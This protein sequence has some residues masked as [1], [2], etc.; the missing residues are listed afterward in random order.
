MTTKKAILKIMVILIGVLFSLV[1]II[2]LA[3]QPI[4]EHVY[5]QQFDKKPLVIAHAGSDLYPTD[6]MYAFE[7]YAAMGVDILEMDTNMTKDGK[8]VVIHDSKLDRTTDGTGDISELTLEESQ[9][10]DAAYW[11]TTDDGETYP[12][13]GEGIVIPSLRTV[14]ETFPEYPMIIEIKQ[15]SPSMAIPL[16]KLIR[17]YDMSERVLVP[18]FSDTAIN[19]FRAACPEVATAASPSEVKEFVI[20]NFLLL[21]GT[22]KPKYQE[23]QV[24]EARDGIPIVNRFFL[25]ST[26]RMNIDVHIWTIND[27]GE[28]QKFIDM[29][30]DGIMTDRTDLLIE[31]L[32]QSDED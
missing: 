6:T 27:S 11:W 23:L 17:E 7:H 10:Y 25:W 18:S 22:I 30:V 1:L 5:F 12:L 2:N 26:G 19:E 3:Q 14:F 28:M 15:E 31:I 4:P 29:N 8:I 21:S 16:C 9:Q 24:P 20:R 32:N 13:R